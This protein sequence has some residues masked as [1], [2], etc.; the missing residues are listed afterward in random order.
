M[1]SITGIILTVGFILL[2]C[3]IILKWKWFH[4]NGIKN[5]WFV[6][7]YAVKAIMAIAG[8]YLYTY[9]YEGGDTW[10]F[11]RD[12]Q[13][14]T[15]AFMQNPGDYLRL[16]SGTGNLN[17]FM[18]TYGVV[19]GW[20][21]GDIVYNDNRTMIVLNSFIGF[22]SSGEYNVHAIVFAF[23]SML[24]LTALYKAFRLMTD[25][26]PLALMCAVFLAP[27]VLFWVSMDLKESLMIFA[28]GMFLY[29]CF[30]L[31]TVSKSAGNM[32]GMF[33]SGFLFVHIKAYVLLIVTPCL[34]AFIW[35]H[36]SRNRLSLLRYSVV[37]IVFI[38]LF[39]NINKILPGID[40]VNI[41]VMK[42]LNFEAFALSPSSQTGSYISIPEITS[43]WG[44]IFTAAPIAAFMVFFRPYPWESSGLFVTL[45]VIENMII[46]FAMIFAF[47]YIRWDKMV[48]NKN[49]MW[50]CLFFTLTSFILIGLTTPVMGSMVRYKAP[51]LPFLLTFAVLISGKKIRKPT[52]GEEKPNLHVS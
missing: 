49:L 36:V 29:H 10:T 5:H 33:L 22:F 46:L 42:R 27:G 48:A 26:N 32:A 35:V 2:F 23:I 25:P 21:N 1:S 4:N 16:I 19:A 51:V 11:F 39:F 38:L 14:L 24:G 18:E 30:R 6:I 13:I 52:S 28:L 17:E 41:I 40:P 47:R 50:L 37:Y 34:L 7:I 31:L 45:A 20:D 44:D 8:G 12:S 9:Y 43:S 15:S 3:L